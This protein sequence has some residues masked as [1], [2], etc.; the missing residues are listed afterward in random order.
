M[1]KIIQNIVILL[2]LVATT[3]SACV[4]QTFEKPAI[5]CDSTYNVTHTIKQIKALFTNDTLR[6][7]DNIIIAGYVISSD[8]EGNFY[9]ELYLQD[10]TTGIAIMLDDSYLYTRFRE[11][12]LVYVKCKNLYLGKDGGGVLKLGSLYTENGI[13]KFGRIQGRSFIDAHIIPSCENK[14]IEPKKIKISDINDN[15]LHQLITIDSV[16]FIDADTSQTYADAANKQSMSRTIIDRKGKTVVLYNSGYASFASEKLPKGNGKILAVLGKYNG[17]YQL[18]IR[19]TKDVKFTNNRV[20]IFNPI[21]KTFDDGDIFSGR[22]AVKTIQG[23]SWVLGTYSSYKY[24]HCNNY[25]NPRLAAESWYISPELDLSSTDKPYLEFRNACKYSGDFLKV[26]YTTQ[27]YDT[28]QNPNNLT[29]VQLNPLLDNNTSSYVWTNS[30]KLYLPKET[31]RVAFKYI[32]TTTN[33]R[34]WE[35]D[36]IKIQDEV[37]KK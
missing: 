14:L 11:G 37:V 30:G 26:Y 24:I 32:G 4:Q 31:K 13:V 21:N 12:Q 17:T 7:K 20:N 8:K 33:G 27:D 2:V 29:W 6:I 22:W 16:Q 36:D 1:K 28:A 18:L 19:S 9:K 35:V 34:D 10:S 15:L 25:A 5:N 3:L 23:V